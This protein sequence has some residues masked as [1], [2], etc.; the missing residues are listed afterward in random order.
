MA[1]RSAGILLYRHTP[2][3]VD[4]FLV[5]PGGPFWAKK[6]IGAW[7]IPKGECEPGEDGLT[8]ARREFTEE[9]GFKPDG[10]CIRLGSFRQS[11]A[12]TIEVWALEADVDPSKL[13]SNTFQVE[14]PPRSGR[15]QEFPE[16]DRADWFAPAE[17]ARKILKG[18]LAILTALCGHL[19]NDAIA[20]R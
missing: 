4:V 6:D 14:W 11:S 1:K 20:Q 16:V 2:E 17:A 12:K 5:H 10:D 9:T 15:M 3:G 8:A 19:G 7:S 18:Q 13:R